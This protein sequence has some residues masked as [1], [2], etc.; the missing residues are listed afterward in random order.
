MKMKIKSKISRK[1]TAKLSNFKKKLFK[2]NMECSKKTV[3]NK[4]SQ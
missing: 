4:E 2:N 3:R 1:S